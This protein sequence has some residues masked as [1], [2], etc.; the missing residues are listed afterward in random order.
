MILFLLLGINLVLWFVCVL[1]TTIK[2]YLDVKYKRGPFDLCEI[3]ISIFAGWIPVLNLWAT[4]YKSIE[5]LNVVM[6]ETLSDYITRKI[7]G[8]E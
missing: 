3:V 2:E 1:V 6:G 4:V 5:I 8:Q 7:R